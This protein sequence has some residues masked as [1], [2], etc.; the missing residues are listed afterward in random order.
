ME[1]RLARLEIEHEG[2]TLPCRTFDT[3]R[4]VNR[5][6]IVSNKRLDVVLAMVADMQAGRE[7]ERSQKAPR[8]SGQTNHMFVSPTGM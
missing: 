1:G 5:S 2:T 7:L 6:E 8:R 4:S 3:L